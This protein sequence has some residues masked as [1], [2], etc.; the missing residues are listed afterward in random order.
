MGDPT[1]AQGK[2]QLE[3]QSPLNSAAKIR[4][5][6][7]VAQGANDPRVKKAE[8]DQIVIALRDRGFPVEYLV[9]PDEGH[10]FARPVNN[11]AMFA[12]AEKFLARY[13]K[14]RFQE[15]MPADVSA[16]LKEITVD[17][18]T[19]VLTRKLDP[20]AI[21]VPK[22]A[23]DLRPGT[24]SYQAKIELGGQSIALTSTTAIAEEGGSWVATETVKTPSGDVN[25]KAVIE[26]GS[27]VVKKRSITQGPMTVELAFDGGKATGTMTMG[28]APK[29]IAV[30][31]GG[32]LFA[33]GAGASAAIGALPLADGYTTAFRNF[34]VQKQKPTLKQLKVAATEQVTVPAGTFNAFKVEVSSADGEPGGAT[35]WIDTDT[36]RLVKIEATLPQMGGAKLISELT[37]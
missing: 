14:G 7:L 22:P 6:L 9:A 17:P 3:R 36:R 12:A 4:T 26:K 20:S 2:A 25:D 31:T 1:T 28:G 13:L 34:D 35:L 21:G 33:D 16:R 37:K 15:G 18:K 27:L 30:D 29:A 23:T 11:M 24:S 10:G 19:V 32:A 5:P 8:S